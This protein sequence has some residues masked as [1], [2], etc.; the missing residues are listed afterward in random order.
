MVLTGLF[1]HKYL[2]FF[3]SK[4]SFIGEK[5][6]FTRDYLTFLKVTMRINRHPILKYV[7]GLVKISCF[8]VFK[9]NTAAMSLI[10][11]PTF[12]EKANP[13]LTASPGYSKKYLFCQGCLRHLQSEG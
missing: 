7:Y 4:N 1:Y 5:R 13:G 8:L 9:G 3:A 11:H 2:E 6:S 12:G 10:N